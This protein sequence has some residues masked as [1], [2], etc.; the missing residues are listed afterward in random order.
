MQ[1]CERAFGNYDE[2][3]KIA[4]FGGQFVFLRNS[5]VHVENAEFDKM[6][7]ALAMGRYA[8]HFHHAA[9]V[10][11]SYVRNNGIHRGTNR[12][13]T[14]HGSF[15]VLLEGNVCFQNR[16]HNLYL[17]DGIEWGNTI[18]SNLVVAPKDS[19]TICTD[20]PRNMGLGGATGIWITNPNNSF[21][22]NTVVGASFGAWFTFPQK[23]SHVF[24]GDHRGESGGIFGTSKRHFND[25]SSG[26]GPDSWIM[27]QEQPRTPVAA[28]NRNSFK[29]SQR[30]AITIDFHVYSSEDAQIPCFTNDDA[31]N[32][33]DCQCP[34]CADVGHTFTWAPATFDTNVPPTQ[35]QYQPLKQIFEDIVVAHTNNRRGDGFSY[36][37][38]G[39]LVSFERAL[40]YNNLVGSSLGFAGECSGHLLGNGGANVQFSNALF[41]KGAAPFRYYDGGYNCQDCRWSDLDSLVVMRPGSPGNVNGLLLVRSAPLGWLDSDRTSPLYSWVWNSY[42]RDRL[43]DRSDTNPKLIDWSS[44]FIAGTWQSSAVNLV[45]IDGLA[46]TINNGRFTQWVPSGDLNLNQGWGK[47]AMINPSPEFK[48]FYPCSRFGWCGDGK[49][50]DEYMDG[51]DFPNAPWRTR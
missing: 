38:T 11:G 8:L 24:S 19:A 25:I 6:G 27:H 23:H 40:W 43:Q 3:T 41:M 17:E 32:C 42:Q 4:C 1:A 34:T 47:G 2:N 10:S 26:Y 13:I 16:G 21:I 14:L 18:K 50:C 37:A 44:R 46:G 36:W 35:R 31:Y 22:D 12:C 39:G 30:I 48:Q 33:N 29:S 28:F 9:D 7:Q 51:R 49:R 20:D 15:R 45:S 5:V